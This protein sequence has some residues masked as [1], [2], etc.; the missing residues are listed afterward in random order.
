MVDKPTKWEGGYVGLNSFGFGGVN[1]HV[2][3]KPFVKTATANLASAPHLVMLAG[4]TEDG[5]KEA[6]KLVRPAH[7]MCFRSFNVILL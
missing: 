4:K 1:A 5:V 3:L 6:L 2:I 7:S